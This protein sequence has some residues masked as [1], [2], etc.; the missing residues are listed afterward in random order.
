MT[1]KTARQISASELRAADERVGTNQ[2]LSVRSAS[3]P[4][5]KSS[6]IAGLKVLVSDEHYKHSLAIVRHLG[7]LGAEITMVASSKMSL[8]CRSRYC[9][10]IILSGASTL[11]ALTETTLRA[12]RYRHF[13]VVIP[14]SYPMT[15]ALAQQRESVSRYTRL[16]IADA[17]LIACAADKASMVQLAEAVGVPA[18]KTLSAH[19]LSHSQPEL[20]FPVVIKAQHEFPGHPPIRYAKDSKE[21]DNVLSEPAML[22]ESSQGKPLIVQEFVPGY[23]CGFF[24][25]YQHGVCK[26]IFM[27]RRVREY[28]VTG[29]VSSCAESFYDSKLESYGRKMLDALKWHGVAMVEF[30]H[31][32]R[33]HE[34]KLMEVNPKFWGSLDLALAA[35]ADFPGD[36]CR[37]A[38]GRTLEFSNDY[39]RNLRFQWPLSGYGDLF[40]LWS[41]PT[42]LF[43]V[44][45][46]FLNPS[47]K[48][49]V[50][51]RDPQPNLEEVRALFEKALRL[52]TN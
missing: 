42:A 3:R 41:R 19:Q 16:E 47:V 13:D 38:L 31:D 46:D 14:V 40:H 11:E 27:H 21:L 48:S 34:Y 51:L 43:S 10:E 33:N 6:G 24:A 5:E 52:R 32:T 7:R 23:G 20:A 36:L 45:R 9:R 4:G 25:T 1:P 18:P 2:R 26:R 8:A 29:G 22:K 15:V 50:W 35:G 12:I 17:S 28:P 39:R 37:M 44:A 30:R 49:N